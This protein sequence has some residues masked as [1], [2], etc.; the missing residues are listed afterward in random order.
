MNSQKF[1]AWDKLPTVYHKAD[2][3]DSSSS[4]SKSGSIEEE[5]PETLEVTESTSDMTYIPIIDIPHS[6]R[7]VLN[8]I[9]TAQLDRAKKDISKKLHRIQEKVHRAYEH[10]KKVDGFDPDLERDYLRSATWEEKSRRSN[11]LDEI[12]DALDQ[13]SFKQKELQL[14][15]ESLKAWSMF[16]WMIRGYD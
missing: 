11:F 3:E 1:V 14:V 10:Y 5:P 6:V 7:T 8:K 15:L 13:S 2:T 9:D 4:S 16:H 12:T